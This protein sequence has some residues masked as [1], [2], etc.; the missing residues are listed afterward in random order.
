MLGVD[1]AQAKRLTTR[2][3]SKYAGLALIVGANRMKSE[4]G[5]SSVG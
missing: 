1:V 2:V 3:D 5:R 4:W